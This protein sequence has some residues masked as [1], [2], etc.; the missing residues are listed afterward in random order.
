VLNIEIKDIDFAHN[1]IT[2]KDFKTNSTYAAF[3]NDDLKI[4]IIDYVKKYDIQTKLFDVWD[5]TI[6][7]PLREKF[8]LLFNK[9][10]KKE[11]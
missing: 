3:L 4:L 1:F 5:S 9:G 7:K 10:L 8:N 2:I 11:D 6:A